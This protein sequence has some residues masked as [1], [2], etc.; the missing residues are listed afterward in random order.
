[1]VTHA[2]TNQQ[3]NVWYHNGI[4]SSLLSSFILPFH[5]QIIDRRTDKPFH[6]EKAMTH[7]QENLLYAFENR[8]FYFFQ[9]SYVNFLYEEFR[10]LPS[11]PRKALDAELGLYHGVHGKELQDVDAIHKM[12]WV[13]VMSYRVP[14]KM[15]SEPKRRKERE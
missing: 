3:V 10:K 4:L 6:V 8:F 14:M 15:R 1:M 12:S 9:S 11:F 13:Q 7:S 5:L 2:A